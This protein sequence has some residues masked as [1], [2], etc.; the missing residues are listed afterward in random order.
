MASGSIPTG[1]HGKQFL[2][3]RRVVFV[4]LLAAMALLVAAAAVL[5]FLK[6]LTTLVAQLRAP[7]PTRNG[8]SG[9]AHAVMLR[10]FEL[11]KVASAQVV[12]AVVILR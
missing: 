12:V 1:H 5:L 10:A 7:G 11:L 4:S 2:V 8:R 9:R 3:A 6:N